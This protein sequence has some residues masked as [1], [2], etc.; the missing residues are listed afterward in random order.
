MVQEFHNP[1]IRIGRQVS[2]NLFQP[3]EAIQEVKQSQ[4]LSALSDEQLQTII[5]ETNQYWRAQVAEALTDPSSIVFSDP[6]H[7]VI[8]TRL[9]RICAEK[10]IEAIRYFENDI[11]NEQ[12]N[13]LYHA[14]YNRWIIIQVR[15]LLSQGSAMLLF[16]NFKNASDI[17]HNTYE[18]ILTFPDF[19][20][21]CLCEALHA[22]YG[23]II[24]AMLTKQMETLQQIGQELASLKGI[25][26]RQQEIQRC[27]EA[28][29]QDFEL[30]TY[31]C[32]QRV[33]LLTKPKKRAIRRRKRI[34]SVRKTSATPNSNPMTYA[35]FYREMLNRHG[36]LVCE[37]KMIYEAA[38]QQLLHSINISRLR[39]E[40]VYFLAQEHEALAPSRLDLAIVLAKLNYTVSYLLTDKKAELARTQCAYTLG[41]ALLKKGREQKGP[42][43]RDEGWI[44]DPAL[45]ALAL[46]Y[47]EEALASFTFDPEAKQETVLTQGHIVLCYNG[48]GNYEKALQIGY[49]IIRRLEDTQLNIG[50]DL[51]AV[52][53]NMATAY[54][55]LGDDVAA[56]G[57]LYKSFQHYLE[58]KYIA[59]ASKALTNLVR[60]CERTGRIDDAMA[61]CEK[62]LS[63]STQNADLK[64]T[65][66]VYQSLLPIV[67]STRP[68]KEGIAILERIDSLIE[69]L[70]SSE[71]RNR[72]FLPSYH[73]I[74]LW[75]GYIYTLIIGGAF[76]RTHSESGHISLE[77]AIERG[78][79][80]LKE[81]QQAL[82]RALE[83]ATELQDH[84]LRASTV[85]QLAMLFE[86][87]RQ[88]DR[89][90]Q[91]CAMIEKIPCSSY[92]LIRRDI[93][94]G[95]IRL[96]KKRYREALDLFQRHTEDQM[97]SYEKMSVLHRIAEAFEGMG[98]FAIATRK[99]EECLR[100]F[101]QMRLGMYEES[102][103]TSMGI[104]SEIYT[105]LIMLYIDSSKGV[106][107]PKR[108]L[109]WLE[110][111]K[112]RTFVEAMGVSH[113]PLQEPS[114]EIQAD[115]LEEAHLLE[116][117][118]ML[119]SELFMSN[120]EV[121]DRLE[122]QQELHECLEQLG[123][124]WQRIAY[125]C[126]EYID[127]RQGTTIEWGTIQNILT[128]S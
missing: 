15:C 1:L 69:P 78:L 87:G 3:Q 115:V 56:F 96:Q 79:L 83:I 71:P 95:R 80:A 64:A 41:V 70:V 2:L 38:E 77:Q 19:R 13:V 128:G 98:D 8:Y 12:Q 119:R 27:M 50:I 120:E 16:P 48:I 82:E 57:F 97:Q 125:F 26:D 53:G 106:Y 126:P 74:L 9:M 91:Y 43:R 118:N 17:F 68:L 114:T 23:L 111:S 10:R 59:G 21:S 110:R 100:Y 72:E 61:A 93:I 85:L 33:I 101:E 94:L 81:G 92:Y 39:T 58:G 51:G 49:D 113:I 103:V 65:A 7:V 44:G 104:V 47:L 76:H 35:L 105:Q 88:F 112:S 127:L 73:S 52:Y 99:Y 108:G 122:M 86:A 67:F 123:R 60:N 20:Q 102:R 116:R 63:L 55:Q 109:F 22:C 124:I 18:I 36:Q 90:E 45:C 11:R 54:E 37:E 4:E 30:I 75:R 121:T 5:E 25:S 62:M 32:E 84:N 107:D 29:Q 40:E 31:I 46:P 34:Q 28:I 14:R 42:L 6:E 117:L 89:V 24:V 66:K